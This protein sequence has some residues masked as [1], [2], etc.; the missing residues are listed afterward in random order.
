MKQITLGASEI[1]TSSIGLGCMRIHD[2]EVERV[3]ELIE[4]AYELGINLY[5]HADIYGGG[6]SE[7]VF[8]DAFEKTS[9]KREDI[10]VQSKCGIR[11]GFYD[12]SKE[13][14]VSSV[15]GILKRLHTDYLDVLLLHRPDTLMEP[16]EVAEAFTQLKKEGKVRHFGVS[17]QNPMQMQLLERYLNEKLIVNQL[18]FSITNC[19]MIDAGLNVNMENT[20]SCMR[21]G[22]VL[23]YCR[24]HDVTIQAWSPFQYG[25]FEG[26]FIGNKKFP[27]LNK[28]LDELAQKYQVS[29][30]AIA[31]AWIMRHPAKI[32]TILG[33]TKKDRLR[34][35]SEACNV[36]LTKEE[37]YELYLATGKQLP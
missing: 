36:T 18:Q 12:F 30:S 31:V 34:A 29:T 16:E 14:I 32:Q 10:I 35:I 3:R 28:K 33:T 15:N 1:Q 24:L 27:E 37:W 22:S 13:Y 26:V 20:K 23:E 19:T 4:T 25:F 5:D 6:M 17:N 2:M 8:A 9:I 11:S 7:K 21:D